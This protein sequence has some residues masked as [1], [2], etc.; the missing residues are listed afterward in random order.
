M[1][2]FRAEYTSIGSELY[3]LKT[4]STGIIAV[5]ETNQIIT[6]PNPALN[7]I[8]IETQTTGWQM[9]LFSLLGESV[10]NTDL[11]IGQNLV[12]VSVLNGGV[13]LQLF[14]NTAGENFV[15]KVVVE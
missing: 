5:S 12:D 13:Y 9:Q 6:Y 11:N 2:L 8:T 15:N 10:L 14:T 4:T 1:L 7:T 3:M